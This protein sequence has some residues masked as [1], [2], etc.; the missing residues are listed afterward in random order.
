VFSAG[1]GEVEIYEFTVPPAWQGHTLRELVP[2]DQCL[3]TA[4]TR[5]G[6]AVLPTAED[7]VEAGDV[8]LLSA[9]LEGIEAFR[10]RLAR[11]EEE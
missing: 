5:A 2:E 11:P 7:R 10:R 3:I 6:R 4:L 1:N 8:V 9:T